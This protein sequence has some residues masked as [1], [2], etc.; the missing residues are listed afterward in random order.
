M[1]Q[2]LSINN[3]PKAT[4]KK[5]KNNYS[6][7]KN[8]KG[9]TDIGHILKFFSIA[10]LVFGV[11]MIGSGSYSMFQEVTKKEE[12]TKPQIFVKPPNNNEIV[13]QISHDKSLS[14]VT[15]SW[16]DEDV[17]TVQCSGKMGVQTKIKVLEGI[18]TLTINATD[19]NGETSEYKSTYNIEEN[20]S[21]NVDIE[22]NG[23]KI[24]LNAKTELSYMTYRWDEEEETKID[25]NSNEFEQ[26]IEAPKG[27]HTLTISAVDKNNQTKTE[28]QK[29]EGV[30]KPTVEITAGENKKFVMKISDEEGIKKVEFSIN[31]SDN[32]VL[33]LERVLPLE[34]R[35]EFEYSFALQ[36]GEN[37]IQ[38]T[39][40]NENNVTETKSVTINTENM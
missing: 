27:L 36:D 37:K 16:D 18:H 9:P 40:H 12:V 32:Y 26:T 5:E 39:A 4:P 11:F 8:N 20:I 23:V 38:V 17:N 28:T 3:T 2:I 25:I 33:D 1:N 21:I 6:N 14:K 24:T 35:K 15:Y 22:G 10:I 29:I 13:I 30:M 19:I 34:E 31:D 7:F